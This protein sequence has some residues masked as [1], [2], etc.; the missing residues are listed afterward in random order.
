MNLDTQIQSKQKKIP[1]SW[2]MQSEPLGPK[3]YIGLRMQWKIIKTQYTV[4]S[5]TG[6]VIILDVNIPC[7]IGIQSCCTN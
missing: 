1:L 4:F 6:N 3:F 7:E 2:F 5:R